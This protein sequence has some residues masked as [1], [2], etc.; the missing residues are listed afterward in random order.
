VNTMCRCDVDKNGEWEDAHAISLV[1]VLLFNYIHIQFLVLSLF[2]FF[3]SHCLFQ[4]ILLGALLLEYVVCLSWL[5]VVHK[6]E[7]VCCEDVCLL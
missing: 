5:N 3:V 2:S 6:L 1:Y 7:G 4:L